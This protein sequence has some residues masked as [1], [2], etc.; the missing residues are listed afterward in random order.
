MDFRR[1]DNHVSVSLP[2]EEP[3][4]AD[5]SLLTAVVKAFAWKQQ[6][7]NNMSLRQLAIKENLSRQ[8]LNRKR[9]IQRRLPTGG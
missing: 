2:E 4:E 7:D 5:T 6:I 9:R 3:I 1:R 8:L